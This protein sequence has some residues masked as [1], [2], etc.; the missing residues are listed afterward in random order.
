MI[1]ETSG[2]VFKC[3]RCG[4]TF[5][6]AELAKRHENMCMMTDD[7]LE[8]EVGDWFISDWSYK[9]V[10]KA[11]DFIDSPLGNG[12]KSI[13]VVDFSD[14]FLQDHVLVTMTYGAP[15]T[16]YFYERYAE[17]RVP[18]EDGR[19]LAI[20][21]LKASMKLVEDDRNALRWYADQFGVAEDL[22]WGKKDPVVKTRIFDPDGPIDEADRERSDR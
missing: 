12:E 6:C 20:K 5:I 19:E 1:V 11:V 8:K 14:R 16:K 18:A 2:T 21:L 17:N 13:K 7:D 15:G 9:T 10:S 22:G 4:E 3:D